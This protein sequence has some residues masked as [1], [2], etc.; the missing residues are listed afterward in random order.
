MFFTFSSGK[1]YHLFIYFGNKEIRLKLCYI[2]SNPCATKMYSEAAISTVYGMKKKRK[3]ISLYPL[4]PQVTYHL[5]IDCK[6]SIPCSLILGISLK[7]HLIPLFPD[8]LG[9]IQRTAHALCVCVYCVLFQ[10]W[11][12][13]PDL[14]DPSN[15]HHGP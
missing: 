13:F 7:S 10:L 5:S 1:F 3:I 14:S 9:Q 12:L 6:G 11:Y 15:K 2:R 4:N 8:A